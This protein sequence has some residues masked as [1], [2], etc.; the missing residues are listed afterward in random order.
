MICIKSRSTPYP[1]WPVFQMRADSKG[2]ALKHKMTFVAKH[3]RG[4]A[5]PLPAPAR[6]FKSGPIRALL[7]MSATKRA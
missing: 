5:G 4:A 7:P 1:A 3:L 6:L 2:G